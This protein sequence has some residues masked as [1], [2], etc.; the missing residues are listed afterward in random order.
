[1]E[2]GW[3]DEQRQIGQAAVEF[4]RKL[5]ADF[6]SCPRGVRFPH[7]AWLRC[8]EF[9]VQGLPIPEDLGGQGADLV[10]TALVLESLGYGCEDN[11]LAVL[12]QC[13]SVVL[14]R[15]DLE[16]RRR[17]TEASVPAAVV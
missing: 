1:M 14:R 4:G 7:Q 12:Y 15:A 10:T 13:P 9:G 6:V 5:N 17:R 2:F 3:T 16:I 11:G 8:A